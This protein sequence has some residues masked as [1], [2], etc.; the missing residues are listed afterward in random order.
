MESSLNII[1]GTQCMVP[2]VAVASGP[3]DFF[4][5]YLDIE[6]LSHLS[7]REG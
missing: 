6:I 7:K 5:N 3:S 1:P 4:F 2:A